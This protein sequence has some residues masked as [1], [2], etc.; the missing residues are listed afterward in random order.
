MPQTQ[1]G[2]AKIRGTM[3]ES[4]ATLIEIFRPALNLSIC[5]MLSI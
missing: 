3:R 4:G 1:N 5:L 2:F